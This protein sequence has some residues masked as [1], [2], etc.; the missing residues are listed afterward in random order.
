MYQPDRP[1]PLFDELINHYRLRNDAELAHRMGV[2]RDAI[3]R[4][5]KGAALSNNLR[6]AI[7]RE[8]KISMRRLDELSPP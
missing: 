1:H 5:R 6:I 3:S 7:L 8:F 2:G 4:V